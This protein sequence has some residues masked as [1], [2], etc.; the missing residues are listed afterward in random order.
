MWGQ[1]ARLIDS[2]APRE[3]ATAGRL[4]VGRRDFALGLI[5]AAA[6]TPQA[7]AGAVPDPRPVPS[8]V[9]GAPPDLALSV[10][11][12]LPWI[13][14]AIT[15]MVSPDQ[16]QVCDAIPDLSPGQGVYLP[17][18]SSFS[19]NY[20]AFLAVLD[21][22]APPPDLVAQALAA[23]RN[24]VFKTWVNYD[25]TPV[26]HRPA[27]HVESPADWLAGV[28]ASPC[29][30]A[31]IKLTCPAETP[32]GAPAPLAA[33]T[34]GVWSDLRLAAPIASIVMSAEAW[35]RVPIAPGGWFDSGALA[36]KR[37][38]PYLAGYTALATP[39]KTA[40]FGPGGLLSGRVS[41]LIVALKPKISLTLSGQLSSLEA[42]LLSG[43]QSVRIGPLE[44]NAN[45][46]EVAAAA[47]QPGGGATI[48]G[49]VSD[50]RPL[51]V[52]MA[53]ERF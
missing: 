33:C 21:P 39:G 19:D 42:A 37:L 49:A 4:T 23:Y 1:L 46:G 36:A 43:A 40:L 24:D 6:V 41:A 47:K 12:A 35:G 51:I 52:A 5:G 7:R 25:T 32:A 8:R 27:W 31:Q 17:T 50:G 26:A 13:W 38:G 48:T 53:I 28:A 45:L 9:L 10:V 3:M 18:S 11:P 30:P 14:P 29:A 44:L 16:Q 15:A 20:G 2:T 22:A 34:G